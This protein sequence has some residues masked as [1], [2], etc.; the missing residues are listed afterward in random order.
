MNPNQPP[1]SWPTKRPAWPTRPHALAASMPPALARG[2]GAADRRDRAVPFIYLFAIF[3]M[4]CFVG[5]YVVWNVTPALHSPLMAVTNA[6]SS[7][8]VVGAMLATGLGTNGWAHGVRLR[9]RHAGQREHLRRLPGDPPDAVDVQAQAVGHAQMSAS[10]T[11]LAYLVA[12]VL[13]I[14]ALRGLSIP[15][16]SRQGNRFGMIGMADR[17]PRHAGRTTA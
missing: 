10:L 2:A 12:A 13:F 4:A 5:Y 16:T 17:R 6:I 3:L 15:V 14:L 1:P 8:I 7:V 11:A 9:R